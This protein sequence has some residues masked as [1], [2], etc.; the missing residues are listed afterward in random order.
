MIYRVRALACRAALAIPLLLPSG[1]SALESSWVDAANAK[2]RLLAGGTAGRDSAAPLRAGIEIR[3]T[4]G[5]HTY[6]RYAGDAGIPPHFDWTGS[7][8]L[9]TAEVRWP[10]PTRIRVEDGIES[11]GYKDNVLLPLHVRPQDP[12]KPVPLRLKLDFGVSEKICSPASAKL[13]L[14]I[15]AGSIMINPVLDAAEARVPALMELGAGGKI[16]VLGGKLERGKAPQAIVDVAVP[17]GVPF[18]LFAEG[19]TD[20]WALPLPKNIEA[21]EGRKR[22]I[23]PI[24]GAPAGGSPTPSKLRLTLVAGSEAIEVTVPLY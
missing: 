18:D 11:I 19:P 9:R 8:N 17:P 21:K 7:V 24:D 20:D 4:R 13:A 22:F 10:A 1:A 16:R 12:S 23:I 15:P 14:N 6:W 2:V 3:L 5:W